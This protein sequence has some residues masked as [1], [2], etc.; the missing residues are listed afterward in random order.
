[1]NT[2]NDDERMKAKVMEQTTFCNESK[3]E[4]EKMKMRKPE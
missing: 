3:N 1:L 4:N 2:I